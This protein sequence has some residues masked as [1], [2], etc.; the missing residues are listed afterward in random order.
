MS[1]SGCRCLDFLYNVS[2]VLFPLTTLGDITTVGFSIGY[3]LTAEMSVKHGVTVPCVRADLTIHCALCHAEGICKLFFFC[4]KQMELIWCHRW[5][6]PT[7]SF[8]PN[9]G[10]L[11]KVL[12]WVERTCLV[13]LYPAAQRNASLWKD[14]LYLCTKVVRDVVYTGFLCYINNLSPSLLLHLYRGK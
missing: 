2:C 11:L 10:R 9:L 13:V 3:S 5:R 14:V 1:V 12:K 7:S 4:C 8:S 6:S